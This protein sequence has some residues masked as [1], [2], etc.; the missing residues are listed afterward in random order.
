MEEILW[1]PLKIKDL[2]TFNW[3]NLSTLSLIIQGM[4][5]IKLRP[6]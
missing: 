1:Y 5:R 6:C 2:I 4:R 3:C